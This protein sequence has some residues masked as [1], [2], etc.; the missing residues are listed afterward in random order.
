MRTNSDL[1]RDAGSE[2]FPYVTVLEEVLPKNFC[3]GLIRKFEQ[4]EFG[5]QT[6]TFYAGIRHFIEVNISQNWPDEHTKMLAYLIEAWKV[7]QHHQGLHD[8]Q[9][10]KTYGFEAFRMK[11]YLPNGKDEF[12]LHTDVG[13]HASARRFVSF[14][15]YLNTVEQGGETQF[16]RTPDDPVIT[17]P[18]VTGRVLIFPPLWTHPHW[19]CK[20]ISGPKYIMSGYLHY[21]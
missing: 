3:E 11:R 8:T 20:T 17:I 4:N 16:G 18:A 2:G 6:D 12:A 5:E 10:P 9:Y 1:T 7:Y 21:L 14:L 13:S 15:F 19:G